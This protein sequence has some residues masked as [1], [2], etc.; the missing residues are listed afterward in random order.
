MAER[1]SALGG[2]LTL[3]DAPDD[4]QY[5]PASGWRRRRSGMAAAAVRQHMSRRK[6]QP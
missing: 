5:S 4:A 6:T 3:M 1:A 2:T